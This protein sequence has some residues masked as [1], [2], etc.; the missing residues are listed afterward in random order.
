MVNIEEYCEHF[1]MLI[2]RHPW[3]KTYLLEDDADPPALERELI[4]FFG[5]LRDRYLI[6]R[7]KTWNTAWMRELKHNGNAIVWSISGPAQS[8]LIEPKTGTTEERIESART[9]QEVGYTIR[10][11]FK[12]IVPMRNW[13]EEAEYTVKLLFEKTKPDVISLCVFMWNEYE[14]MVKKLPVELLDPEFL[15]SAEESQDEVAESLTK[16]FPHRMRKQIYEF[17]LKETRKYDKDILVSLSTENF[18]MWR[19]LGDKLGFRATN[20]V[21]GRGPQS[22][23]G[24]GRLSCH[25][26]NVAVRNDE[27]L[28]GIVTPE[29]IT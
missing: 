29:K 8:R 7:T 13:R 11:K 21:C 24:A 27:G 16:P 14:D 23:P 15:K 5:S 6:I 9:V 2:E 18:R 10:Y 22:T 17:Y 25:P 1:E 26:F 3:Q 12:P 19:E 20:Y 28:L 4:E